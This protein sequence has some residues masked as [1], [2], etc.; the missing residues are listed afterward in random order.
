MNYN[1]VR[2]VKRL[3]P[4]WLIRLY[5][6]LFY[7][8]NK[9]ECPICGAHYRSFGAYGVAKR[10][11]ALCFNCLTLER[12]R[13]LWLYLHRCTPVLRGKSAFKILHFAPEKAIYDRL[14]GT[15][16]YTPCDLHPELYH[17]KGTTEVAKVDI[18]NVP[19][20]DETFDVILC[21]HVLEHIEDDARAM[22]ELHRVLKR[23]GFAILQVPIDESRATTYED[24]SI[25]SP[26]ERERAFGQYDHVR[27][28]G[29][30]YEDRLRRAGF[31]V[32]LDEWGFGLPKDECERFALIPETI[33]LCKK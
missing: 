23:E 20:E 16:G 9:V 12:H 32:T 8:G 28:Y 24:F 6:R 25:A 17:F 3:N 14:D 4:V 26:R 15:E 22:S 19:F 21:N 33:Y 2:I 27:V 5:G 11:N 31:S 13:L 18:C 30:D 10:H 7:G 1:I 29:C